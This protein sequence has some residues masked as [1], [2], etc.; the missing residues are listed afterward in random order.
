MWITH[1]WQIINC[2]ESCQNTS[3]VMVMTKCD[4]VL[5]I[6]V[7]WAWIRNTWSPLAHAGLSAHQCKSVPMS[8]CFQLKSRVPVPCWGKKKIIQSIFCLN[9]FLK[10]RVTQSS[11]SFFRV[12]MGHPIVLTHLV[13]IL[14]TS[15]HIGTI[16]YMGTF[17]GVWLPS[18]YC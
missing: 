14:D 11:I 16:N 12:T 15:D 3:K 13:F 8:A 10:C 18:L 2:N 9:K 4:G 5:S 7:N 6:R 17:L 1:R